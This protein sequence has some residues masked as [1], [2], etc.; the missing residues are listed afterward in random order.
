MVFLVVCMILA[1]YCGRRMLLM[2]S[3]FGTTCSAAMIETYFYFRHIHAETA[4]LE[5][6]PAIDMILY[7]IMYS[8]GFGSIPYTMLGEL[9]PMSVKTLGNVIA[10]TTCNSSCFIVTKWYPIVANSFGIH[11]AS[12]FFSVCSFAA[13]VFSYA[14]E[15]KG[16]SLERI[17][18][19]LNTR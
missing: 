16:K 2:I 12:W 7:M 10:M 19:E 4:D 13:V 17:Q 14:Y 11:V 9:F 5:W 8:I 3:T 18:E 15:T 6:L 1:D